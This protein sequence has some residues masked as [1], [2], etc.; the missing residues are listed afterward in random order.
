MAYEFRRNNDTNHVPIRIRNEK[1]MSQDFAV[2]WAALP[3]A[4]RRRSSGADGDRVT[5]TRI[6]NFPSR[7][8]NCAID[9]HGHEDDSI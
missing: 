9:D 8:L 7:D 6:A 1:D 3:F 2:E 5:I 4:M